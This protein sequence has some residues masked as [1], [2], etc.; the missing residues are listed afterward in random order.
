MSKT[1]RRRSSLGR[2]AD[3][4][5]RRVTVEVGVDHAG[6]E[7]GGGGQAPDQPLISVVNT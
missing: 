2:G 5:D 7:A 4:L 6:V 1:A 3:K